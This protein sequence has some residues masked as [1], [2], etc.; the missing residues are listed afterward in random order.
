MNQRVKKQTLYFQPLQNIL[1][2]RNSS[3]FFFLTF[4]RTWVLFVGHLIPLFWTS[5]DVSS[6][7]QSQSG[8][9]LIRSWR[10][11]TSNVTHFLRFTSGATPADLLAVSMAAKP[12]SSTY[13]Q[14]PWWESNRIPLAPW[15]NAQPTELCWLGNSSK[16]LFNEALFNKI[17]IMRQKP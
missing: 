12:I 2:S 15:A 9:Y 6:G 4:W 14:R 1:F 8:F 16:F 13:L 10:R 3:K 5:G 7:F 17:W 11:C